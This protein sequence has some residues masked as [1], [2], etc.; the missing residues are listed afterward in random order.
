MG[1]AGIGL[2]YCVSNILGI[3]PG[4]ASL[5]CKAVQDPRLWWL[6]AAF[7][8]FL[9]L[10]PGRFPRLWFAGVLA[11]ILVEC[12]LVFYQVV[13]G[14]YCSECLVFTAIFVLYVAFAH[15]IPLRV[16]AVGFSGAFATAIACGLFF[17]ALESGQVQGTHFSR[18]SQAPGDALIFEPSCPH[19]H[20]VLSVLE[21][22]GAD[23][24]IS[25]CPQAWSLE[26]VLK[27]QGEKCRKDVG[28]AG[29]WK[30]LLASL[31]VVRE[32]N[33]YCAERG[34]RRVPALLTRDGR[35]IFGNDI[36]ARLMPPAGA[37][38]DTLWNLNDSGVCY[39]DRTT[40][41]CN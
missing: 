5:G 15:G 12:V 32:N 24:R 1:L 39:A 11:G 40:S 25:L 13:L 20:E 33:L 4:C 26:S 29:F 19:C 8:L 28:G 16:R 17:M 35:V 31:S 27:L 36:L 2:A 23:G 21:E 14:L 41:A 3:D 22:V 9:L 10:A 38:T 30:C 37:T 7:C 6:G 34:W 18:L